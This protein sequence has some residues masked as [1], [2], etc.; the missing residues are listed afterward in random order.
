LHF[1]QLEINRLRKNA[2]KKQHMQPRAR[3]RQHCNCSQIYSKVTARLN[4]ST[5]R[6]IF[7]KYKNRPPQYLVFWHDWIKYQCFTSW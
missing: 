5:K 7:T 1:I 6:W 2:I 3:Y 4:I